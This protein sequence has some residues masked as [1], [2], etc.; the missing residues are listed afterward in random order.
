MKGR[1]KKYILV[2][3]LNLNSNHSTASSTGKAE[4]EVFHK[5]IVILRTF[6]KILSE[7]GSL[8]GALFFQKIFITTPK[9]YAPD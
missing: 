1:R 4:D 8:I 5:P 6:P 3:I 2:D 9:I 7:R